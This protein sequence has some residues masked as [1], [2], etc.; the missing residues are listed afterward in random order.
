MKL[1][2]AKLWEAELN[3]RLCAALSLSEQLDSMFDYTTDL[4]ECHIVLS[5]KERC[6]IDLEDPTKKITDDQRT[7]IRDLLLLEKEGVRKKFGV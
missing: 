2:E 3:K 4:G 5:M 1:A 7:T 6:I